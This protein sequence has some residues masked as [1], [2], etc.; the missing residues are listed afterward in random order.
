MNRMR[1]YHSTAVLLPD[2]SVFVGGDQ[3]EG[4]DAS[5]T[6]VEV[7]YPW[8]FAAPS[9]PALTSGP[10]QA[11]Y[12]AEITLGTAATGISR[13][14]IVRASS[15][16]HAMNTDQRVVEL[17]FRTAA[18]AVIATTP[19]SPNLA[20]PGPYLVFLIDGQ[21]VPSSGRF[22]SLTGAAP[23][24]LP[25]QPPAVA[26]TSPADGATFTAP[27]SITITATASDPDGTVAQV[28]FHADGTPLGTDNAAPYGISWTNVAAGSYTLTARATDNAGGATTSAPIRITVTNPPPGPVPP[29][30]AQEVTGLTLINADTDQPVAGFDPLVDGAV[31][32]LAKLPTRNL[33]L[34]ANTSPSPVGSVRFGLD[35][36][37]DY[38]TESAVPYA[39]A[40]DNA[41]D[42]AAWTPSL[43]AHSVT[44]TPYDQAGGA[45]T[46]GTS[47]ALSFTVVD[48]PGPPPGP[49]PGPGGGAVVSQTSEGRNG[50]ASINDRCPLG[51]VA[52]HAPGTWIWLAILGALSLAMRRR[53]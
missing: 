19:A 34:R 4:A 6:T 3:G 47:L 51:S 33:N 53:A 26:I 7:Y 29:P 14:V 45:G 20:P 42:Y 13:V 15:T 35:G 23:P 24:P 32:N 2:G 37:P 5:E 48:D 40:G 9:R 36:D 1:G 25:N 8:Y 46:A 38:R 49:P 17:P 22:V 43:G 10:G 31:L 12:G 11:G 16:T 21:N 18:G 41:G 39:L 44:A 50:D 27:A 52:G 30:P 28:E